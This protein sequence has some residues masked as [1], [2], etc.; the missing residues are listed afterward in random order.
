[1][2][3]DKRSS[4]IIKE[5]Q[6]WR[7]SSGP[8]W[9]LERLKLLKHRVIVFLSDEQCMIE[10][11][12]PEIGDA[13]WIKKSKRGWPSGPLGQFI[14]ETLLSK[15]S[16]VSKSKL[17]SVLNV[18]N[19]FTSE[20]VLDS[21]KKK[22]LEA[23]TGEPL[24]NLFEK[25]HKMGLQCVESMF[26]FPKIKKM[27]KQDLKDRF[28]LRAVTERDF[29]FSGLNSAKPATTFQTDEMKRNLHPWL[30][31]FLEGTVL[32][33]PWTRILSDMGVPV[34]IS[35]K[36]TATYGGRISVL[37]Q[38]G[39][40]AR[41]IAVP[42]AAA[43]VA[44]RPLHEDLNKILR[45]IPQDCTHDQMSGVTWASDELRKGRVVHAV[46][47]SSA[48]DNFPLGFQTAV[49]EYLE[50]PYVEEFTEFCRLEFGQTSGGNTIRYTKGQPMGLYGSF[51][52]F[53]LSHHVL[54]KRIESRFRVNDT[55]RILGDDI[56]ISD[57]R[58]YSE[59]L[60]AME[61]LGVPISY[62]KCL[63]SDMLTE[64]AGKLIDPQ[65]SI[66][67]V[68]A[69]V[70]STKGL[71][72]LDQFLNYCR[73]S[74]TTKGAITSVPK[75]FRKFAMS[76]AAL[77]EI[78]GGLGINP[79]GLSIAD[80]VTAF[81]IS[82]DKSYPIKSDLESALVRMVAFGN[83]DHVRDVG[84]YVN[85]Q[86]TYVHNK[87]RMELQSFGL[88]FSDDNLN[89]AVLSQ[90]LESINIDDKLT[91]SGTLNSISPSKGVFKEWKTRVASAQRSVETLFDL[92]EVPQSA[93]K[94][95]TPIWDS[96]QNRCDLIPKYQ[97]SD[98]LCLS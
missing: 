45:F 3:N 97:D 27:S 36:H 69:P 33:G 81:E 35:E 94:D 50:Y 54:L 44:F 75:K 28:K 13:S 84:N 40:R 41:V 77:P 68:K 72:N 60:R 85:N 58:V 46:D 49:L 64:F 70:N 74:R 91:N 24:P 73:V 86:L 37:Q 52:L 65:G 11:I 63:S 43:Q 82:R 79:D 6:R 25:S 38:G 30:L 51:A 88:L 80:R 53:A 34:H 31:S 9:T 56:V 83:H 32:S 42:V 67:F 39:L 66:P 96:E 4:N 21:Q 2:G 17:I 26:D 20:E 7:Q 12:F 87:I 5:I 57:D 59:Y 19:T 61:F 92:Q 15:R 18:G 23:I 16:L 93:A 90:I 1:M 95:I 10:K 14:R 22:F 55:Y 47:L 62:H 98:D 78:Y 8:E 71:I 48:T 29:S 76:I 89:R